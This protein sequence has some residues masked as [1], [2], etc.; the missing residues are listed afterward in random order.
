MEELELRSNSSTIGNLKDKGLLENLDI[1]GRLLKWALKK[2]DGRVWTGFIWLWIGESCWYIVIYIQKDATLDSLFISGNCSKCFG[3]IST[4]SSGA[5]KTVST[6]SGTCQTVIATCR[7]SGVG[8][9]F[10]L[11]HDSDRYQ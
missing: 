9:E 6:E 2:L 7:Y 5:H 11:L 3:G 4:P 1:D 8:T 10:Q